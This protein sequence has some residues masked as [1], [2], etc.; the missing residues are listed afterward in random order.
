MIAFRHH[1]RAYLRQ[2]GSFAQGRRRKRQQ[3]L[4]SAPP[5]TYRDAPAAGHD[6]QRCQ[7]HR[8]H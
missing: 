4:H 2:V 6:S 5:V 3:G 8:L 7:F 1:F